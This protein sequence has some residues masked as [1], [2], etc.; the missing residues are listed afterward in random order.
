MKRKTV[1]LLTVCLVLG[2]CA[3]GLRGQDHAGNTVEPVRFS[4]PVVRQDAA[5]AEQPQ[6]TLPE[7]ASLLTEQELRWFGGSCFNVLPAQGPNLFLKTGYS[8]AARMDLASLFAAG[9]GSRDLSDREVRQLGS[10]G[11]AR[12]TAGELEDLLLRYTGLGLADMTDS[13][14]DGLVYLADFDAYYAPGGQADY[15]RFQ[16][17]YHSPDGSVTLRYAGG[18]VTLRQDAGRWLVSSNALD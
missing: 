18:C 6:V 5:A 14:F 17:G 3:C 11:Y 16:Y 12:L 2:L 7:G 15:V 13:A 8:D 10:D 1:L 4:A 9:A